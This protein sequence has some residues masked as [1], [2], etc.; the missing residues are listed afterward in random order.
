[1]FNTVWKVCS[2]IHKVQHRVQCQRRAEVEKGEAPCNWVTKCVGVVFTHY[3]FMLNE[4]T[5]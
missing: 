2:V 4:R 5:V 3:N 1:M